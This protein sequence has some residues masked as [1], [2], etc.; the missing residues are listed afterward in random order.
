MTKT[1][2]QL[3]A[4]A[5]ER[6]RKC[7]S[8]NVEWMILGDDCP[9]WVNYDTLSYYKALY[10]RIAD[11]LTD[12]EPPEGYANA[13]P[14]SCRQDAD[15]LKRSDTPGYE[16]D[17]REKLEADIAEFFDANC[18]TYDDILEW[19]DRQAAITSAEWER[20][21][22]VV[23]A[24]RDQLRAE[25]TKRDKGIERL[26]RRRDELLAECERLRVEGER[27]MSEYATIEHYV[28]HVMDEITKRDVEQVSERLRA[29]GWEE[30]V[31]CRDCR[32]S[33][34]HGN[35]CGRNQDI[36]DAEPDGFCA[37]GERK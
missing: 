19:L 14:E 33:L 37:W 16:S 32:F 26:K 10:E 22:D 5:V 23:K 8:S 27:R 2:R 11:L 15:Q 9:N 17:S 35:G 24:E 21:A 3:R 12:D 34:A 36:Y 25:L 6:L 29:L 30:I 7:E 1:K 20:A 4:E 31:R 18:E 28:N 13:T